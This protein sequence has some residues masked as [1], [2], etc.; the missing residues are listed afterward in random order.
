MMVQQLL[1]DLTALKR[2]DLEVILTI[3]VPEAEPDFEAAYVPLRVIRNAEPKGFGANHN[4]AFEQSCG[5]FFVVVNPDIR[6]P[7][8][9][10]DELLEPFDDPR[11]G[12]CGPLVLNS[13]GG[14]ED[15]AR[16]FPTS[17][18]L[19]QRVLL[20]DRRANYRA[21]PGIVQVDWVA[22]MFMVFRHEAFQAVGGFDSRRFFM[23]YEDVDICARLRQLGWTSVLQPATTVVHD[24][25]RASRRNLRHMRWHVTSALR[26][27]TGL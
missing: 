4:C 3:N 20:N 19:V 10:F 2:S 17:A 11:T 23:Y 14:V 24:A 12:I 18:R 27:L 7:A 26:Y 8:L 21:G 25:Q 22:G 6:V 1:K 5:R 13:A 15:S 9:R 16:R